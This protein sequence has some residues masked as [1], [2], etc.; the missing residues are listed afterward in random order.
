TVFCWAAGKQQSASR[1]AGRGRTWERSTTPDYCNACG[2]GTCWA[3]GASWRAI[4]V[5]RSLR[6]NRHSLPHLTA[7][8]THETA[9]RRNEG[10]ASSRSMTWSVV[11]KSSSLI[12]FATEPGYLLMG[13]FENMEEDRLF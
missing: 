5:S 11:S 3:S 9:F 6:R 8:N 12:G 13:W 10:S 7:P 4:H 2:G 1:G